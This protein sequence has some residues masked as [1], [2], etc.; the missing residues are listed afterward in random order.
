MKTA[1]IIHG[2]P[3]KDEYFDEDFLSPS[4]SHWLPWLQKQL[5]INDI[6]AQTP[7]FPNAYCPVYEEWKIIFEQFSIDEDTILV[8]HSRGGGFL[9]RYLSEN[10][11]SVGTVCLVAPS[12]MPN[13][14]SE[15]GFSGFEIDPALLERATAL[16]LY[17]S[18]DDEP[19]ILES[20]G[21]IKAALPDMVVH[22][23]ADKGH[24]TEEDLG[25]TEFPEL[26]E[27][28]L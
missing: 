8:G 12:L 23:F 11:I 21:A 10:N 20:V 3:E 13:P 17:Y 19:G 22:E 16:H 27:V 28:I 14:K 18:T 15:N 26:L 1:I 4:N 7:E 9:V 6:L 2:R 5:L 25:S 24:F